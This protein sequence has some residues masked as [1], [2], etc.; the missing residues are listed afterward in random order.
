MSDSSASDA[1]ASSSSLASDPT[2]GLCNYCKEPT[3]RY[4]PSRTFFLCDTSVECLGKYASLLRSD[5]NV[6]VARDSVAAGAAGAAVAAQAA[7]AAQAAVAAGAAVAAEAAGAAEAAEAPESKAP[8]ANVT[9]GPTII[10]AT[11]STLPESFIRDPVPSPSPSPSVGAAVHSPLAEIYRWK[12]SDASEDEDEEEKEEEEEEEA[13]EPVD[14]TRLEKTCVLYETNGDEFRVTSY[15]SKNDEAYLNINGSHIPFEQFR[16]LIYDITHYDISPWAEQGEGQEQ[17][18]VAGEVDQL[19][20]DDAKRIHDEEQRYL[21]LQEFYNAV[22]II[23][24]SLFV[25]FLLAL[26]VSVTP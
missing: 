15:L 16:H 9:L 13:D 18:E 24:L 26:I 20:L 1:S 22:G 19:A 3:T 4:I 10:P 21:E 23:F 25:P 2:V 8:P 14:Y 6:Y 11:R 5:I 17:E 7:E 12:E